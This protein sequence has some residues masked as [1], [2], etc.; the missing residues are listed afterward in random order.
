MPR[1]YFW[2]GVWL[3]RYLTVEKGLLGGNILRKCTRDLIKKACLDLV[4]TS[5]AELFAASLF[6]PRDCVF[7][8][9]PQGR[10]LYLPLLFIVVVPWS[11]SVKM[12][13]LSFH[14]SPVSS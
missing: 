5:N 3:S 13:F 8:Q 6:F 1:P 10:A 12:F 9:V 2:A 14:P 4:I 11:G 7:L